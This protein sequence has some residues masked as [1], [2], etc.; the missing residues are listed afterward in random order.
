VIRWRKV[1]ALGLV[2]GMMV[3]PLGDVAALRATPALEP[4]VVKQQIGQFGVGAK[5]K[6]KLSDGRQLGGYVAAVTDDGFL[7]RAKRQ[8]APRHVAYAEASQVALAKLTYRATAQPDP[9]EARRVVIGLGIAR[10]IMAKTVTGKEYHGNI[11][12]IEQN[13]FSLLPDHQAVP[14]QIA[15][16]DVVQLGPN[17][18]TTRKVIIVVVVA[19]L[20]AATVFLVVLTADLV[21]AAK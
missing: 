18:S 10:H 11:Q 17:M 8:R 7:L 1:V 4:G 6:V 12:A 5:I 13:N 14:I 21:E 20:V 9:A 2:Y 19:A 3:L 16:D 15:Y